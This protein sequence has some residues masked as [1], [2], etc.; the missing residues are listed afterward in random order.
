[1]T[2]I[3]KIYVFC[4]FLCMGLNAA[5]LPSSSSVEYLEPSLHEEMLAS[6]KSSFEY[7][8]KSCLT[9]DAIAREQS[10]LQKDF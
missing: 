3:N 1:M 2:S 6:M 8:W 7:D 10:L 4:L 5:G 9:L